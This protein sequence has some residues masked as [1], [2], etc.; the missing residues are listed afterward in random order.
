MP[1][2]LARENRHGVPSAALWLTTGFVQV[3]LGLTFFTEA[4]FTLALELTSSLTL[5]PYLLV[6]AYAVKLARSGETYENGVGR[7]K[8]LLIA[9]IATG[10]A[11]LMVFAGGLKYLLLSALIY[12]PGTVLYFKA[13]REQGVVTFNAA[14]RLVFGVAV[15]GAGVALA[16]MVSGWIEL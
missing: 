2:V 3:F 11:V 8:D 5:I 7:R 16:G 9:L 1:A 13:R 4:A 6:A 12:A 15:L 10:Y 14:E